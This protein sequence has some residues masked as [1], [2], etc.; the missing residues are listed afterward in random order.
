VLRANGFACVRKRKHEIWV[1]R[2]QAD[3]VVAK[4]VLSHGNAE[5]RSRRLFAEILRQTGKTESEFS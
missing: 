4:T 5:I 2:D 3:T 1:R